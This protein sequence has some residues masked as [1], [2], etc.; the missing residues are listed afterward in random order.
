[1]KKH[2]IA[3]AVAA[4]F[5]VPAVAQVT[6]S[7]T[8]DVGA[9]SID[10]G[11]AADNSRTSG[12]SNTLATSNIKF[13]GSEDLGGGLK[14]TFT[15]TQE[16]APAT[17][18]LSGRPTNAMA[19]AT[20]PLT[21]RDVFQETSVAV[22]GGF[23]TVKLG[24]F[25]HD[26]REAYGV[27]RLSGNLGRIDGTVF[28][29]LGNDTDSTIQYT[30]PTFSGF[31]VSAAASGKESGQAHSDA[32]PSST[33]SGEVANYSTRSY[34][35]RYVQGPLA[36]AASTISRTEVGN[37]KR[38]GLHYGLSYNFGFVNLGVVYA[39]NEDET[40]NS[41]AGQ[42]DSVMALQAVA[43]LGN[44]LA[45][46]ASYAKYRDV[47]D[48]EDAK[49]MSIGVTKDL[50]K[51]TTVYFTYASTEN[52]EGQ[53]RIAHGGSGARPAAGENPKQ[54]GIGVRHNF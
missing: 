4:A 15:I 28:R 26:A 22:S 13:S 3:A 43:P 41:N 52:D 54:Y 47:T 39:I 46:H 25:N 51:R 14:A 7:G 10:T 48:S 19:G 45:I 29:N 5:A 18:A 27:G 8:V 30:S 50:S 11:A 42:E 16:F 31:T 44:G 37:L 23:G 33:A 32:D 35:V 20:Q 53:M 6:L 21:A 9:G 24:K 17:G 2:I 36:A 40:G 38:K 12:T 1:M 34:A 49:G